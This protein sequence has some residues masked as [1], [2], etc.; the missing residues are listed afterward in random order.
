M[1]DE[2][3]SK[4][5]TDAITDYQNIMES[6]QEV[7]KQKLAEEYSEKF[8][9]I[10]NEEIFKNKNKAKES[11]SID[12]AQESDDSDDTN[13]N[14]N[15][16]MNNNVKKQETV[17]VNHKIGDTAP[18]NQKPKA[19]NEMNDNLRRSPRQ[20]K[21]NYQNYSSNSWLG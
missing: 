8:N 1:K 13:N 4:I 12:N 20:P 6:A 14:N 5:I 3:K 10:L 17:K 19:V 15:S 11:D 21:N 16:D 7:A 9:S 2:K 18:F